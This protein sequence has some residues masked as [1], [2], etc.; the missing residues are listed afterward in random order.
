M[1][2]KGTC[3]NLSFI[4]QLRIYHARHQPFLGFPGASN[5]GH[6]P[7][8]SGSTLDGFGRRDLLGV[9]EAKPSIQL[10][11]QVPNAF[12]LL[13]HMIPEND[14][15]VLEGS[16]VRD[17]QS[18]GLFRGHFQASAIQP[19]LCPSRTFID[20][21]LQNSDVVSSAHDKCFSVKPMMLVPAD[22][23]MHRKSSYMK[24]QTSEPTRDP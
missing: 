14:L 6:E 15:Q 8:Q 2:V 7:S 19:T 10:Y 23:S 21:Q 4:K 3:P 20:P 1:V 16:P 17:Q 9:C 22:R 12:F 5:V 13:N 24:I 11:T 18:L